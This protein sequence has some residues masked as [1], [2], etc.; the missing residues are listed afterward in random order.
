MK[1]QN[2]STNWYVKRNGQIQAPTL[3]P[4]SYF[5]IIRQLQEKVLFQEDFVKTTDFDTW[6]KI[7]ECEQFNQGQI[8]NLLL[9]QKP[10]VRGIFLRREPRVQYDSDIA[11]HYNKDTYP[12][13]SV[14]ISSNGVGLLLANSHL[15]VGQN[16][17]LYFKI[18]D[19]I[20]KFN[21]IGK[22][23]SKRSQEKETKYGV[24]F[25]N[26]SKEIKELIRSYTHNKAD[27]KAA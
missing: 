6:V 24:R 11:V 18:H 25:V 14:E 12:G 17:F 16:L 20:P 4:F 13:Q 23:V 10:E 3:G 26:V 2:I 7:S 1:F 15:Y 21:A 22:I 8:R 19:E 5:E 9:S 27:K